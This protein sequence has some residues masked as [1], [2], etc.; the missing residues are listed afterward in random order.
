MNRCPTIHSVFEIPEREKPVPVAPR[1][2]HFFL[3]GRDDICGDMFCVRG[4]NDDGVSESIAIKN[5]HPPFK[6]VAAEA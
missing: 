5:S 6:I 4:M 2:P 3:A 1:I